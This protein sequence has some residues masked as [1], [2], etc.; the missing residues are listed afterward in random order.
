MPDK[1]TGATVRDP[2]A[3]TVQLLLE[4]VAA[5][6]RLEAAVAELQPRTLIHYEPEKHRET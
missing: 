1:P 2:V 6:H 3:E 5:L 4:I